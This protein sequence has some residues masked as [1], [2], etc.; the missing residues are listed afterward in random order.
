MT[1]ELIWIQ[2]PA[3][4]IFLSLVLSFMSSLS[5]RDSQR[6]ETPTT[7]LQPGPQQIRKEPPRQD[8]Y[9]QRPASPH[10]GQQH[11]AAGSRD[12]SQTRAP[13]ERQQ[14]DRASSRPI[15]MVQTYQPPLMELTHDTLP[16]LQPIFT[17]L[18][19]HGNKLYQEGYFLK[20]DDQNSRMQ[21][22]LFYVCAGTDLTGRR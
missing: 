16:E 19:S 3:N 7:S 8:G 10:S 11:L 14:V 22:S 6:S 12:S 1:N 20:L 5:S 15:S 17:Y 4:T 21:Y 18:N 13:R 9:R 2:E